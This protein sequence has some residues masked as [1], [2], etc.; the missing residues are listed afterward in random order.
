MGEAQL[1]R[2]FISGTVNDSS[3]A[4]IAGVQVTITNTGTNILRDTLTNDTGFYRF[5]AVE[6]GTYSVDFKLALFENQRIPTVTVSTAQE[7][8]VNRT[9]APSGGATE[10]TVE[11]TPGVD[12]QKTTPTIERTFSERLVAELPLQVYSNAREISRLALL[13][14]TVI[15]VPGT[16]EF[17][18]N[19]Q[20]ARNNNF[21]IDG[22]D[23]N[24]VSV[25]VSAARTI[26]EAVQQVQIQTTSYSAEFGRTSGA[27]ISAIT[28]SGTNAYHCE[29]WDYHRGSW[30]EPLSLTNK[31]AGLKET[32]R[33]VVND[34]G[35][36]V[37]GPI[38]KNRT[39]FFGLLDGN[40]RRGAPDTRNIP[41]SQIPSIP[42][43]AGYAALSS[44]P[45]GPGQ[46]AGSRQAVLSALGFLPDIHKQVT[47]YENVQVR[48]I[49]GTPVEFGT[50]RIPIAQPHNFWYNVVHV[51]HRLTGND[52]LTYRYHI[53]KR[54]QP[55]VTGNLAFGMRWEADQSILRQN[56][57]LSYTRTFSPRFLNE[58]RFGYV[59]SRLSF[60]EHDP[61][62]PTVNINTFFT[63]GGLAR[64]P[65]GRVEQLYE[66]QDV[67]TYITGRHSLKFGLDLRDSRLYARF[68]TNS[69]GNWTFGSFADY[70]NNSALSLVQAVNESTFDSKQWNHA[71]F[72]Q[73]DLKATKDLTFNLGLRYEYWTVPFGF[74]GATDPAIRAVGVQG[75]VRDDKNNWAPRV[76][77]AY[78]PSAPKGIFEKLLG[79]G[80]TSVRGGFGM[81][82]D[83]FFYNILVTPANNY[84]RVVN[85]TTSGAATLNL[86]PTLAPKSNTIPALNPLS[87]FVNVPANSQNPTVTMWSLSVQRELGTAYVLELGYTGNRSYH[88]V[89]QSEVNPAV[90]TATMA[91]AVIASGS[92]GCGTTPACAVQRL[93][94]SWGPRQLLATDAKG[95][96]HAGYVKFDKRMS[97][98]LVLGANYTWSA[99]FS[100]NDEP[101]GANDVVTSSPQVPQNFFNYRNEWS[102]SAFDRPYRFAIHYLYDIPWFNSA[103]ALRPIFGGWQIAG[104]TEFQSG[105]PFT[106]R[107]GVDTVGTL[108]AG[109]PGRPNYNPN[110]IMTKDPVTGDLRTFT[111]PTNGTGVVVAP[112]G[113]NGILANS[114][115]G[116]RKPWTEYVPRTITSKLIL[117]FDEED[118]DYRDLAGSIAK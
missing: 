89:R 53:D 108:S 81:A 111:I 17:A 96:Y 88:Q 18:A 39:F 8:V 112:L 50:I 59:R 29:V 16:N 94:P 90:L 98:G 82:Y 76:G 38:L 21:T 46:T 48:A 27:Q 12:L 56:H 117:Q 62:S 49:N 115:P 55:N 79:S 54:T 43:P 72:F 105:Q 113:P 92:A 9:L 73:D 65:Q 61:V 2:G 1:T 85:Q 104:F 71:Y 103:A 23:N 15:R 101:F 5:V 77:F 109:F 22:V 106:I 102:R 63:F 13:A 40:R 70:M 19:G 3:N 58:A 10:I 7:I 118:R 67:A 31:R 30:M 107:P 11:T 51:D 25:T 87:G 74:F 14:P 91:A 4:V 57:A 34:F 24:D 52:N 114:M 95:E 44:V 66:L 36:D 20:R 97:R 32:P 37:A 41:A 69:K 47:N 6:P 83:V 35:G 86:F 84:P 80:K 78:S 28:K 68:G 93:N 116:G 64:F 60:P 110:G 26:P 99:N 33:F 75:P 45:L 100:D 42:T